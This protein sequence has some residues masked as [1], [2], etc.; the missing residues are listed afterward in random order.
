[1]LQVETTAF[2]CVNNWNHIYSKRFRCG[3]CCQIILL[4]SFALDHAQDLNCSV[5]C[6]CAF[7]C[8]D[9]WPITTIKNNK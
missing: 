4:R 9:E 8:E 1:M 5:A 7:Y 6:V 2:R 3:E